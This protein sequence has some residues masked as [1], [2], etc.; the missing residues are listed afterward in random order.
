LLQGRADEAWAHT[1]ASLRLDSTYSNAHTKQGTIALMRGQYDPARASFRRAAAVAGTGSARVQAGYWT[2]ASYLY[3]HAVAAAR[4][5]LAAV[6]LEATAANLPVAQRALPHLWTAVI[7]AMVGDKA[8]V[9]GHLA[10]A[11]E[12]A[13]SPLNQALFGTLVHAALGDA[14]AAQ[15]NARTYAQA[16]GGNAGFAHT[17]AAVAALAADNT[18]DAER[19][20]AQ[21]APT[22]LLAK[23]V[24]AEVL[25]ANGRTAEARAL[26]D[27]ILRSAIKLD[28]NGPV[29]FGK[30]VARLRAEKL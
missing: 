21:S 27:E 29:D 11:A 7:E 3:Q 28:S 22:D 26:R 5:E 19:E 16:T 14:T 18:A 2:A 23:A 24:R 13:P 8:T 6:E 25:K 15:A 4:R 20:L 17:L 12:I 9:Q 1:E 30:L 10:R